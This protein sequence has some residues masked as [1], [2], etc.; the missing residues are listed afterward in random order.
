MTKE[1]RTEYMR[2]YRKANKERI[3]Q[4]KKER[5][6]QDFMQSIKGSVEAVFEWM[7]THKAGDGFYPIEG[8]WSK[9]GFPVIILHSVKS[10][11]PYS[12]QYAGNGTYFFTLEEAEQYAGTK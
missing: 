6:R 1:E 7:K 9:K 5:E 10:H 8:R 2:C 12:V 4:V 3:A 11:H